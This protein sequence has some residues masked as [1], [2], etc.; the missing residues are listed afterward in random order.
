MSSLAKRVS[1][2]LRARLWLRSRAQT[3][4]VDEPFCSLTRTAL[5]DREYPWGHS[6]TP[7]PN[8][9]ARS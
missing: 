9:L 8:R 7:T 3:T 6:S 4:E 1:R 5:Q 2:A